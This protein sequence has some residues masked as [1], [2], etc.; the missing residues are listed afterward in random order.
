LYP[1]PGTGPAGTNNL[2]DRNLLL[3]PPTS[4]AVVS[5]LGNVL[6]YPGFPGSTLASA[7]IPFPQFGAVGFTPALG[8]T[9]SATGDTKYDSLQITATKRF[10]HGFQAGAAYTW[11]K[12]FA[13]PAT[14]QDF[15]NPS[16]SQWQLQQIPPQALTFNF[17][18]TVQKFGFLPKYAN[19]VT[20]DWEIG[21]FAIYQSGIFLTPPTGTNPNFLTSEDV[22]TGQPL[23]LHDINNI[24]SYSPLTDVVLNPAAWKQVDANVTGPAA[25]TL[26]TDFRGPR[27]PRENANLGRHFRI[28][29]RYDF[30]IRGEFVNIFNRTI[31]PNPVTTNPQ[32]AP[33]KGAGNG[34]ILTGGFGVINAYLA[35]G[36][37]PGPTA[38][39][40]PLTGRSGTVI[41]RFQ[42]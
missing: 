10:S 34:T 13:T 4:A 37:A 38:P 22:R 39:L 32:I 41:A 18:Y 24:H 29:E 42:F 8:P 26:Y 14:P 7:L 2:A 36:T 25:S 1:Y 11:A 33:T 21:F 28:K 15:F 5:R 6:P 16:A 17:T 19:L 20:K 31:L 3:Q 40:T 9:G 30:Y 12:G 27:Q 23:Y 35:P